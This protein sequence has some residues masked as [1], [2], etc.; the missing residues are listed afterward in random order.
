MS[1]AKDVFL[2]GPGFIGWNVLEL[3]INEGYKVTALVRR[4]S[5]ADQIKASGGITVL[6]DLDDHDLIKKHTIAHGVRGF[7]ISIFILC[8]LNL[9]L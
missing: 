6:G 2:I 3:L 5:H 1:T 9:E 4:H 7:T 8:Y